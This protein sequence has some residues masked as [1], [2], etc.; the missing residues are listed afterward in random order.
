[1]KT[2]PAIIAMFFFMLP[3]FTH[4]EWITKTV[5]DNFSNAKK[6]TMIATINAYDA[7]QIFL[8]DCT[9]E[10]LSFAYIEKSIDLGRA[11]LPVDMVVKIDSDESLAMKGVTGFRNDDFSQIMTDE[12]EPILNMLKEAEQARAK[13]SVGLS[14]SELDVKQTYSA[15]MAGA[16]KAIEEFS[17]A[18]G[19]NLK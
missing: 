6:A 2:C 15:D 7:D 11:T 18:C 8:F 17:S 5:D 14:I 12:R 4:A 16:A 3:A 13:I 19:L 1:M 9:K 10:T